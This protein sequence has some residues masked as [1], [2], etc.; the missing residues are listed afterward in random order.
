[1]PHSDWAR[2]D[3][4]YG[5]SSNSGK[6]GSKDSEYEHLSRSVNVTDDVKIV[7][8]TSSYKCHDSCDVKNYRSVCGSLCFI[9]QFVMYDCLYS[10][11]IEKESLYSE[12]FGF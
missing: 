12:E 11:L 10:N 9:L 3:T 5:I 1:M 8:L 6:H 2:R 7:R 4:E